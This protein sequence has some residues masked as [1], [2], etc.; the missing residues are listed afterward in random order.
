MTMKLVLLTS[1][2]LAFVTASTW[3]DHTAQPQAADPRVDPIDAAAPAADLVARGRYLVESMACSDC[4][5]PWTMG[6]NGPHPDPALA[7]SGHPAE[8]VLP[9]A[10]ELPPG[11]WIVTVAATNTAWAGPWGVSFTAN[12][13][14]DDE[15]GIGLW[16]AATFIATLRTGRHMGMGRPLLPP[17][18][19]EPFSNL[20]D[21]DLGAMFAYLRSLPA[22]NNRVP[23]P[24]AP[25]G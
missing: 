1:V 10:P 21:D 4:H 22:I 25:R 11:P 18:P 2:A 3:L 7:Y 6:P 24:I 16:T 8:L 17:M 20:N 15:T 12:L 23:E 5:T 14:P 19:W 13:T 9:P